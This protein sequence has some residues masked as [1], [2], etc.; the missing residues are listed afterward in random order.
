[1]ET[2]GFPGKKRENNLTNEKNMKNPQSWVPRIARAY[3]VLRIMETKRSKYIRDKEKNPKAYESAPTTHQK[4]RKKKSPG[5][6][7][8]NG[9]AVS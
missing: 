7:K 4:K 1:M 2:W 8:Q 3:L 9:N 6:N 5:R